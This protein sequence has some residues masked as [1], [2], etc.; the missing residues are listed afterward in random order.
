MDVGKEDDDIVNVN[1]KEQI[2]QL[3]RKDRL[4]E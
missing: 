2:D 1:D 4:R 3:V